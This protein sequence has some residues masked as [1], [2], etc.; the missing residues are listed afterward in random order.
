MK[1]TLL[2]SFLLFSLL[3]PAQKISY[4]TSRSDNGT[5]YW[6][7]IHYRYTDGGGYDR[8][9]FYYENGTKRLEEIT[10]TSFRVHKLVNAWLQDGTQTLKNGNGIYVYSGTDST[11]YR[12]KDS[13]YN[14]YAVS[15]YHFY[16]FRTPWK[17]WATGN[18]VN[19]LREGEWTFRDSSGHNDMLITFVNG[20]AYGQA[21]FF[22]LFTGVKAESGF[23]DDCNRTGTWKNY[24]SLGN[25]S[26][27]FN[28]VDGQK[29][30]PCTLYYPDGKIKAKG[31]YVQV[32]RKF[33]QICEDPNNPGTFTKCSY[34]YAAPAKNG[35]WFFYDNSGNLTGT[36]KYHHE[37]S[38]S[39]S[40][41][42][43]YN[44]KGKRTR[45]RTIGYDSDY[46]GKIW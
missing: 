45:V 43:Y 19:G 13:L 7:G 12:V 37:T 42:Y 33:V 1:A 25:L 26:G 44:N 8:W 18:Y 3:S 32:S 28:Y 35:T 15:Y 2:F 38:E 4:D 16:E 17:L 31:Q 14:G 41:Q 30:G 24:D 6:T 5:I 36:K 40:V 46:C 22:Y 9:T 29:S 10:D 27:E 34:R 23:L 39:V 11:I 21:T 20:K